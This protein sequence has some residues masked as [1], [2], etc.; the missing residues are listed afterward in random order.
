MNTHNI[1][2]SIANREAREAREHGND[3]TGQASM[4]HTTNLGSRV[5]E[6]RKSLGIISMQYEMYAQAAKRLATV[7][8][9]T[10]AWKAYTEKI[11]LRPVG[12]KDAELSTVTRNILNEVSAM[13]DKGR[14]NDMAGVKHTAWGAFNAVVGKSIMRVAPG[15]DTPPKSILFGSGATLK[16]KAWDGAPRIPA[17]RAMNM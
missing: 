3:V 16:Q 7:E 2:V 10:N 1:A 11:G 14:G 6:V 12:M 4:R 8:L 13:F 5:T 9:T 17:V 15:N